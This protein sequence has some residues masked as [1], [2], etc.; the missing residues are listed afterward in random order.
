LIADPEFGWPIGISR[1][2]VNHL[3]GLPSLGINCASCHI[4]PITSKS[5]NEPIRILGVTS[6][7]DVEKFFGSILAATFRTSDP[8]NLKKFISVYLNADAKTFDA[9]WKNQ[10]QRII[11]TVRDDISPRH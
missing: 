8:A 10:K 9:E 2:N 4:A 3:G 11:A 1:A 6:H 5:V 7:F